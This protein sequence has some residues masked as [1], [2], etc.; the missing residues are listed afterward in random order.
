M[1]DYGHDLLFGAFI[2]PSAD[3]PDRVVRLA[4]LADTLGLDVVSFQDHPYQARFLDTWTL[5]SFVAALT[6][7]V[8]LVPNVANLPLRPPAVLARAVASLDLLSKGR[9]ELGLGAGYFLDAVAAMGGPRY[10]K[11]EAVAA[12]EEGIAVI[13]ALLSE[14][15]AVRFS[16][17]FYSVAGAHPGPRPVHPIEIWLGAYKPRMLELTGRLADGWIPTLGYAAPDE[18]PAM[19]DAIDRAARRAGRDPAAIRRLFNISGEFETHPQGFLRG[20][21]EMWVSQLARLALDHGISG[22]IL[23]GDDEAAL[24]RFASEVVPGVREVVAQARTNPPSRNGDL[25]SSDAAAL[26]AARET[27]HLVAQREEWTP[28]GQRGVQTLLAVHRHLREEFARLRDIVEQVEQGAMTIAR[29]RSHLNEL[30]MRQ[31]YWTLGAFCAAYCRVVGVH[32]TIED[33]RMFPDL[34]RADPTLG[35]TIE[36][37]R[38][39]HQVIAG[40][41]SAVDDAL[42]AAIGD[43]SR[44]ATARRAVDE[45]GDRLLA[46]LDEEENALLEPIGRLGIE[47]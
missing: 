31:N 6:E 29:A 26:A 25:A 39:D 8:R 41:L 40:L 43:A 22:F 27:E 37:L 30:T 46:H 47:V 19:N 2:T 14:Q 15:R 23:A 4:T 7:R 13:R 33:V 34:L 24:R 9:A 11:A 1:P 45:L 21:A 35:P 32:H 36:K 20:P 28:S 16:G 18:L 44:L 42:V 3:R 5:L 38:T 17:R 10:T 12:L